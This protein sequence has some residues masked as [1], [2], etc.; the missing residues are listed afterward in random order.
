MGPG[1]ADAGGQP[2]GERPAAGVGAA[3]HGGLRGRAHGGGT[4]PSPS[5]SPTSPPAIPIAWSWDF[6]DGSASQERNPV[7][8]Y[9]VPGFYSVTLT[10]SSASA[11]DSINRSPCVAVNTLVEDTSAAISLHRRVECLP[12]ARP[13]VPGT[14]LLRPDGGRR[15]SGVLRDGAPLADGGRPDM[16]EARIYL[17][18]VAVGW[19]ICTG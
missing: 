19:W 11:T 12:E 2:P 10:V 9:A 5:P 14:A 16:G 18:G 3:A 7:H 17:D 13:A 6:G 15:P 8:R 4:C 1:G